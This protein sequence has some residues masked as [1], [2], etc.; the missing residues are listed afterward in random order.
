MKE[1]GSA[2]EIHPESA[3]VMKKDIDDTRG[4]LSGQG[5]PT[6]TIERCKGEYNVLL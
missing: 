4:A 6:A 3:F 2:A 5:S 1:C